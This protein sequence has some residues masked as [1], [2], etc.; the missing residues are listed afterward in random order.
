MIEI[1][2]WRKQFFSHFRFVYLN[3]MMF[4]TLNIFTQKRFL[5]VMYHK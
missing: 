1:K 3:F 2:Q 5:N 4:K